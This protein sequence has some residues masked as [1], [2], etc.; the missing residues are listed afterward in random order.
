VAS[1]YDACVRVV[2]GSLRGRPIFAPEGDTTRPTTDRTREAMFNA[3]ASLNVIEGARVADLFAGSGALGIEALSRGA[4]HCTFVER[5]R[6]AIV[7]I[8]RNVTALGIDSRATIFSGDVLA[9]V[10][11]LGQVDVALVDPPYE[12]DQWPELLKALSGIMSDDGVVVAESG[13]PLGAQSGWEIL[14]EK[15][16]GRTWVTFFSQ[17]VQMITV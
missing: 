14:R 2:A 8:R 10:P 6:A 9:R 17:P 15:R 5:D 4:Q 1:L 7:M 16:Y 11:Q 12:F 13:E 3:L